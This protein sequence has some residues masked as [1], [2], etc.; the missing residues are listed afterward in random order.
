MERKLSQKATKIRQRLTFSRNNRTRASTMSSSTASIN[1][2]GS[3]PRSA[4]SPLSSNLAETS[5]DNKDDVRCYNFEDG[6]GYFR[7]ASP[8]I[9]RQEIE[10]DLEDEVKHS[11]SLL[12]QSL[13]RGLPMWPYFETGSLSTRHGHSGPVAKASSLETRTNFQ[14]RRLSPA[15]IL[16][17]EILAPKAEHDSGVAFSNQSPR[18]YGRAYQ[19][20]SPTA[21]VSA[22]AT[23]TATTT[24]NGNG[25]GRFYG[26]RLSTSPHEEEESRGRAR[27]R[28]FATETTSPQSR[29][30][31]RSPSFSRSRSSSPVLFPYSPPQTDALWA[32][33]DTHD[34]KPL[35]QPLAER[36]ISLGVEGMTWLRASL[37]MQTRRDIHSSPTNPPPTQKNSLHPAPA[38]PRRFYSTRQAPTKKKFA[39]FSAYEVTSSRNSSICGSVSVHSFSSFDEDGDGEEKSYHGFYKL[40]FDGA[41]TTNPAT[42]VPRNQETVYSVGLSPD[43]AQPR[44]KRKRASHLLKKLTGLGMRKREP[45]MEGRRIHT[46]VV[47]AG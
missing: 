43:D 15:R 30:R 7:P 27:G 45:S 26:G 21:H 10:E 16:E 6:P 23:A 4:T 36:D 20:I 18:Y 14:G 19:N 11:C 28:S 8:L 46:A 1:I 38:A 44:H 3:R 33:D 22:T 24:G 40:C 47:A 34:L 32:H 2:P 5:L 12:I 41:D 29:S 37:D 35:N 39:N 25:N 17:K 31:S 42:P 9:D 13:D